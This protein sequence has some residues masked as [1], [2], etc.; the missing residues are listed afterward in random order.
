MGRGEF[1]GEQALIYECKRTAT[2]TSFGEVTCL[3]LSRDNLFKVLGGNIEQVVFQNTMRMILEK[4]EHL[5]VLL[6][7]Q[8]DKIIHSIVV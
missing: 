2:I 5:N 8:I 6:S 1:F 4:S 3:S 7:E